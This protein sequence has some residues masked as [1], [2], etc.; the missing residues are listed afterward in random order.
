[1]N[2]G[3]SMNAYLGRLVNLHRKV[4]ACGYG[5][6]D[7]EVALVMLMRLPKELVSNC[8]KNHKTRK[9]RLLMLDFILLWKVSCD[10]IYTISCVILLCYGECHMTLFMSLQ[11]A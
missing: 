1:M 11:I 4:S 5:F 9:V 8:S 6:T 2:S 10:F 7:R 3:E